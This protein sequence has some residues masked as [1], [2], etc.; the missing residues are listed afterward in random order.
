MRL[1]WL[2]SDRTALRGDGGSRPRSDVPWRWA[3]VILAVTFAATTGAVLLLAVLTRQPWL[4]ALPPLV[5]V[6][7]PACSRPISRCWVRV[8]DYR[9]GA[10]PGR[11]T[12]WIWVFIRW[13]SAA[14]CRPIFRRPHDGLLDAVLK[15][16]MAETRLV[17]VC[18]G[19]STGKT[20]A[21]CEAVTPGPAS[22]AVADVPAERGRPDCAAGRYFA[23]ER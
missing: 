18:G 15:P 4:Q 22:R 6:T 17:V 3:W 10:G 2:L 14:R 23:R 16:Q 12:W 20:R 11:G 9:A 1:W 8:S 5:V 21:A 19:S 7:V 13:S